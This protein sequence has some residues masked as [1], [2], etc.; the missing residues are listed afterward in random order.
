MCCN[1]FA[2]VC[3]PSHIAR[4]FAAACRS[5]YSNSR[6]QEWFAALEAGANKDIS[7][8]LQLYLPD[9]ITLSDV[10]AGVRRIFRGIAKFINVAYASRT[11][12]D[13]SM[14]TLAGCVKDSWRVTAAAQL[15]NGYAQ[16]LRPV[17]QARGTGA[18]RSETLILA[19]L[20]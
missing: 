8:N 10:A 4:P 6:S 2:Q 18:Q 5:H 3:L 11:V 1:Y 16:E 7:A 20:G 19:E 9:E 14:N 15:E 12:L 13:A 17:S